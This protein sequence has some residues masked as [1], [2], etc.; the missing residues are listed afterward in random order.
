MMKSEDLRSLCWPRITQKGPTLYPRT[1]NM[2]LCLCKLC[3]YPTLL[4]QGNRDGTLLI[5]IT[6]NDRAVSDRKWRFVGEKEDS[7]R[8]KLGNCTQT[9]RPYKEEKW[10]MVLFAPAQERG[11]ILIDWAWTLVTSTQPAYSLS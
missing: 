11:S 1:R 8:G 2:L 7:C 10:N 6:K 4:R 5:H 3:P 9:E